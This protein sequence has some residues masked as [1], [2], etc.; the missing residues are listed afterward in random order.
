M[1]R[2]RLIL[3]G[4]AI[5]LTLVVLWHKNAIKR[6]RQRSASEERRRINTEK[7]A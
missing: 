7:A 5:G 6:E 1:E 3:A 4:T 2:N